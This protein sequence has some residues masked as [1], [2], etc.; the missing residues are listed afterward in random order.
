MNAENKEAA[1]LALDRFH[2][3]YAAKYPK[4]ADKLLKDREVCWPTSTS[5]PSTGSTCAP[6]TLSSRPS[7]QFDSALGRPKVPAVG[8]LDSRWLTSC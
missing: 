7:P 3:T 5:L 1:D 2:E 6:P 4:A 8:A